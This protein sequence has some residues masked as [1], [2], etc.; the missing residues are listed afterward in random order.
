M[1]KMT[2]Q[3][4]EKEAAAAREV[5]KEFAEWEKLRKALD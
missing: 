1:S 5:D 4:E 3:M 2:T